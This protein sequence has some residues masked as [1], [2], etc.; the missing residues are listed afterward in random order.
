MPNRNQTSTATGLM[1][2]MLSSHKTY[3]PEETLKWDEKGNL[4]YG[5]EY[6]CVDM[7]GRPVSRMTFAS[8]FLEKAPPGDPITYTDDRYKAPKNVRTMPRSEALLLEAFARYKYYGTGYWEP[9]SN[10]E[11]DA[12]WVVRLYEGTIYADEVLAVKK[13]SCWDNNFTF[14]TVAWDPNSKAFYETHKSEKALPECPECNCAN[15]APPQQ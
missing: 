6:F 4:G 8:T 15:T 12:R 3:C 14:E 2:I 7:P 13:A 1:Q 5:R 11:Q 10:N 9:F